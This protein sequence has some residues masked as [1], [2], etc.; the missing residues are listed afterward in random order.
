M[1]LDRIY[2]EMLDPRSCPDEATA[3]RYFL[4]RPMSTVDAWI[5]KDVARAAGPRGDVVAPARRS[6]WAST[7]R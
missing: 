6:R 1:D 2:R 4:N 7:A 3:A 5:A